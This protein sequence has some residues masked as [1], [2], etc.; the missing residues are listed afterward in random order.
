VKSFKKGSGIGKFVVPKWIATKPHPLQLHV[1]KKG[2]VLEVEDLS[3]R[4]YYIFGRN[5]GQCDVV[6]DH[7]SISKQHAVI[8][9]GSPDGSTSACV[10]DLEAGN[11]TFVGRTESELER[12]PPLKPTP[13]SPG[14]CIVFGE[15]TRLYTIR[16][17]GYTVTTT[18]TGSN[19]AVANGSANC[20]ANDASQGAFSSL[21]TSTTIIKK[22][23][24][25]KSTRTVGNNSA[26][27]V[28]AAA[29]SS[30][31]R[32]RQQQALMGKSL[33]GGSASGGGLVTEKRE[34]ALQ[35]KRP[36]SEAHVANG[37]GAKEHTKEPAP[38]RAKT[39]AVV[40]EADDDDTFMNLRKA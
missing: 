39:C 36:S 15:S 30:A 16:E 5:R 32:R 7:P 4:T 21:V 38:K 18:S 2:E 29:A 10:I 33:G 3:H 40:Q 26:A 14:C 27:T 34:G 11:G 13:V 28:A 1:S 9:H 12:I 20:S 35:A 37:N 25:A 24:S 17:Q 6:L 23:K 19:G 22:K 31:D 8:V